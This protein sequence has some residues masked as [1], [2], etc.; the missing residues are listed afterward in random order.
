MTDWIPVTTRTDIR[1]KKAMLVWLDEDW[2]AA[3]FAINDNLFAVDARCTHQEEWLHTGQIDSQTCEVVCPLHDARF[4]LKTG[5]VTQGPAAAP[6]TTYPLREDE[7]GT[8]WLQK[9]TPWWR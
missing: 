8:I 9:I 4:S 7:N 3:I 1:E 2:A 6:L 5:G